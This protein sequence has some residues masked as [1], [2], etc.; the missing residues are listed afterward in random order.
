MH[1]GVQP[2]NVH[3]PNA[4]G[5]YAARQF[6]QP[7]C[8]QSQHGQ[9]G[10]NYI[11]SAPQQPV[12]TSNNQT[13]VSNS[14]R[15]SQQRIDPECNAIPPKHIDT[16]AVLQPD[17]EQADNTS[18][19]SNHLVS[20]EDPTISVAPSE[21]TRISSAEVIYLS[22][23]DDYVSSV[24]NDSKNKQCADPSV[25]TSTTKTNSFLCIPSLNPKP[26]E[27]T[28]LEEETTIHL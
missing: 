9:P 6:T 19:R 12:T 26:P 23:N 10:N 27:T 22:D 11:Q 3:I 7:T 14:C 21:P 4:K 17:G 16:D 8:R 18:I 24:A 1:Y 15:G 28:I 20:S 2:P 5:M 25:L 13:P